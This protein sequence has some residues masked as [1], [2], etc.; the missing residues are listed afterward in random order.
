ML[1]IRHSSVCR[2]IPSFSICQFSSQFIRFQSTN[3]SHQVDI[4]SQVNTLYSKIH[5]PKDPEPPIIFT[6]LA[7]RLPKEEISIIAANVLGS[8]VPSSKNRFFLQN[9]LESVELKDINNRDIL[10]GLILMVHKLSKHSSVPKEIQT[11]LIKI[12]LEYANDYTIDRMSQGLVEFDGGFNKHVLVA[13][14]L[15]LKKYDDAYQLVMETLEN[16]GKI[17]FTTVEITIQH[18]CFVNQVEKAGNVLEQAMKHRRVVYPR[19]LSI[20][21]SK[22]VEMGE[23]KVVSKFQNHILQRTYIENGTLVRLA[24]CLAES[25]HMQHLFNIRQIA[26][27][28]G[29]F[30]PEFMERIDKSI[31]EGYAKTKNFNKA[32][33]YIESCNDGSKELEVVD[34]PFL[35]SLISVEFVDST[36]TLM[37]RKMTSS[38][39]NLKKFMLNLV[40]AKFCEEGEISC[41]LRLIDETPIV[42][43]YINENTILQ[44]IHGADIT[45]DQDALKE[46]Y[47]LIESRDLKFAQRKTLDLVVSTFLESDYWFYIFKILE[48]SEVEF[49]IR[50]NLFSKLEIKCKEYNTTQHLKYK[51]D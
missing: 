28:K 51:I 23:F 19:T 18:L 2:R 5:N 31:A 14:L 29:S 27:N 12:F 11:K 49:K 7:S 37:L 16:L 48:R 6:N 26:S 3:Q 8:I 38:Q 32:W 25:G 10:D 21:L 33:S 17:R 4:Q 45:S 9:V 13:M 47:E 1:V 22:A 50:P 44:L 36:R 24:E 40:I 41:A 30:P 20:F 46:I 39:D 15:K 35:K 42:Q 34:Y 43:P